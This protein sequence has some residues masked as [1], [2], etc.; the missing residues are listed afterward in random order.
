MH[1][2]K[3][4]KKKVSTDDNNFGYDCS[5]GTYYL[6]TVCSF[7]LILPD[8]GNTFCLIRFESCTIVVGV[9]IIVGVV[10]CP[11]FLS[12]TWQ[13][14]DMPTHTH[15]ALDTRIST[16]SHAHTHGAVSLTHGRKPKSRRSE[17]VNF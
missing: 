6:V 9:V 15:P 1:L 12:K 11:F 14:S 2:N 5:E 17:V 10:K 3:L 16:S 8:V 13:L 4:K 7:C